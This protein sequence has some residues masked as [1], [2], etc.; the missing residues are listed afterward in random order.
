M[1]LDSV[2]IDLGDD[3]T[4]TSVG[5]GRYISQDVFLFYE[6]T[7]RDPRRA[8]RSGNTVGIEK[9]LNERQTLQATGSDLGETAVD[10]LWRYEY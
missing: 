4:T 10:W 5:V 3:T 8:N 1:G 6:R 7:F 9:R 2:A